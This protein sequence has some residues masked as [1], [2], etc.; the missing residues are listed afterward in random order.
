MLSDKDV[1]RKTEDLSHLTYV[2]GEVGRLQTLSWVPALPGDGAE[3]DVVGNLSFSPLQRGLAL[4][5]VLDIATFYVPYRHVY[6]NWID[7]IKEGYDETQTLATASSPTGSKPAYLACGSFE[8]TTFPLF[9]SKGYENIWNNYYRP[10]TT[11]SE[12]NDAADMTQLSS[13]ELQYGYRCAQLPTIWNQLYD[14]TTDASDEEVSTAGNVLS[15]LDF[16]QQMGYLRTEQ[17]R[18]IF[19]IRYR[20]II[21]SFGG[22]TT[23]DVDERPRMINRSTINSSGYEV[24]GTG[25]TSLGAHT[26]RMSQNFRHRVPRTFIPEHGVIMTL[27]LVRFPAVW[28]EE[29]HYFM[30]NPNPSYHEFAGDPAIIQT[31]PPFPIRTEDYFSSSSSSTIRGYA[32]YAQWYRS[33]PNNVHTKYDSLNGYPFVASTPSNL[34]E[35]IM[36]N[37]NDYDDMFSSSALAHWQISA[38]INAPFQRR[39]PTARQALL[40]GA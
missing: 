17:E 35:L 3:F 25:D 4:D 34:D 6:S 31:Q 11:V 12:K 21:K 30:N 36:V 32:A 24:D 1:P 28:E 19:N 8:G 29:N 26:G 22:S 37:P 23:I 13:S 27:A 18:E 14:K 40:T 38:R 10:P 7:F 33:H 39:L 9:V 15:L 20:D 2:V 5:A 16:E